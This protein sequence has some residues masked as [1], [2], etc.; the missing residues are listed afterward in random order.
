MKTIPQMF[1]E[2]IRRF[3]DRVAFYYFRDDWKTL[4]YDEVLHHVE[5]VVE[6]LTGRGVKKGDR[7]LITARNSPLWCV[8]SLA[9]SFAGAIGVPV[10][11][12]LTV[13][14]IR[15]IMHDAGVSSIIHDSYSSA[16][17]KE[18]SAGFEVRSF[19]MDEWF[20]EGP[21]VPGGAS[22]VSLDDESISPDDVSSIIYTSGT[23]GIPKGVV[24]T[25]GNFCS[26]A[27]AVI[28]AGIISE[29]DNVLSILPL[30]HT[31]PFMCTFLV[32]LFVGAKVT[33]PPGLKGPELVSTIRDKEVTVFL[34]VPQLLELYLA[35]ILQNLKKIPILGW[36]LSHS[37][38]ALYA[39]R[40]SLHLNVGRYIFSSVHRRFGNQ[41]RFFT[42]GGARLAPEVMKG[43]EALGFTVL[44]GYGLTETSPVITF[45]PMEKKKPGSAGIPLKTV[46]IKV[47]G[48]GEI[49]ARGPMVMRGYYHRPEE[50][51]E[52]LKDN[53][54]HT[55]DLGYQDSE[56][57]LF[58]TGRKKEVIVLSSGKNIYPEDVER[59]Y[60]SVP[61]IKEICV[62]QHGEGLKGIVVPDFERMKEEKIGNIYEYLKWEI[63]G[64]SMG[65]PLHMR[66]KGFTLSS[67]PL[68]RT[69]LGKVRRFQVE[70]ILQ[71]RKERAGTIDEDLLKDDVSYK[72]IS[73]LKGVLDRDTGVKKT[74]SL[75]LDIGLD[76]LKRI[77]LIVALE[78]TFAIQLE[79]DF[80]HDVQTVE[81]LIHKMKEKLSM[82]RGGE[83]EGGSLLEKGIREKEIAD[84]ILRQNLL[85]RVFV[86]VTLSLMRII[87]KI[88][89]C[90]KVT[91]RENLPEPPYILAP[92]H[93][94]YVDGFLL[95]ANV[96]L[97][98]FRRLYF[99]GA[100][101]YFQS[102]FMKWFARV[103]HVIS[104]DPDASLMSALRQSAFIL[105]KGRSLCI[106][107]EGGRTFTGEVMQFKKGIGILSLELV[108]PVVP[109]SIQGTFDSMPR[110]APFPKPQRVSIRIGKP[111]SP[112]AMSGTADPNQA[113]ADRVREEVVKLHALSD[114]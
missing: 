34:G 44:E 94:S 105:K 14:E 91:G 31:Y 51:A 97:R 36:V 109:V 74:D 18:S 65:L 47:V 86:V 48:D 71:E 108:I 10:D 17:V 37:L 19:N 9:V 22:P 88:Y 66:L 25:H 54:L 13:E 107:P 76:S 96:P 52:V 110:G 41:F 24:L 40:E 102:P 3:Y 42:S 62:V 101:R 112:L 92:N 72:V 84:M 87:G 23:T 21:H 39:L 68:P 11:P 113:F 93:S 59:H 89:F 2:S 38:G 73:S 16:K 12:E 27:E 77:E 28:D 81:E 111:V 50:T 103:A 100:S 30:H 82:G 35:G 1:L 33:Y 67:E 78:K 6:Q 75:E 56:G 5:M 55:G 63:N 80:T 104:I 90:V 57:Y 60:Q 46:E 53:W 7:V 99:Q 29:D 69:P 85:D 95:S 32:P 15:N 79:E 114:N 64:I 70:G 4:S 61:V 106:F 8:S 43:L 45:N 26:D 49:L 20:H 98:V 83:I 58:V